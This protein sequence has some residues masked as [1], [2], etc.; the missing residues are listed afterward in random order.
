[1][2]ERERERVRER[3]RETVCSDVKVEVWFVN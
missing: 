1:M 3:E 2:E